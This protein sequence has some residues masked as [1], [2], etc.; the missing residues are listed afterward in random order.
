MSRCPA[1][2]KEGL[3]HFA[4]RLA[5][6]IDGLGDKLIEQLLNEEL[7]SSPADLYHLSA[8]QVKNLERM[9]AKSAE[10]LI[11]A[12]EQS[13]DT[14]LARFIYALGI[15]EVGEATAANLAAHFGDVDALMQASVE[16][17]EAVDDVGPIVAEHIVRFFAESDNVAMVRDLIDAGIRWEVVETR[18]QAQ[19]LEGQTWVL[20]GTLEAMPRDEAKRKLISLGAKVSG[21]VS[22]KTSQVVAGPGA[23]SKLTKAENLGVPVMDEEALLAL[24]KDHGLEA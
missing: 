13:K 23:G 5:L 6:D 16:D 17:L 7:I 19:P 3:A 11:N 21:S 12:L 1:Q 8:D 9:G 24:L 15:R 4:S 20:T 22:G 10:N 2:R 14:T 18:L